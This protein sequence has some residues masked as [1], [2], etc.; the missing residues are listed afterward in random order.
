[1][2]SLLMALLRPASIFPV[3]RGI[4]PDR[5]GEWGLFGFMHNANSYAAAMASYTTSP[6]PAISGTDIRKG[7]IQLNS[8]AGAGFNITLPSTTDILNALSANTTLPT[9][10]SFW[11]PIIFSNQSGQTGTVT[12]AD[13][14]TSVLGS[15][16]VQ[17]STARLMMMRVL[18]STVQLTSIGALSL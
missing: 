15:A 18:G 17:T 9:D 11:K 14:M 8:G 2:I 4:E 13:A 10:G 12:A 1:M 7:F 16:L 6:A 3:P 5:T